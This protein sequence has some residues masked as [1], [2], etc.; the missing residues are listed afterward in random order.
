MYLVIASVLFGG[1]MAE[2]TRHNDLGV[3]YMEQNNF[4]AAAR[5]FEEVLKLHPNYVIG[6]IN[7]GIAYVQMSR[8]DDAVRELKEALSLDPDNPYAHYNLG[9]IYKIRGQY[10][11]AKMEFETVLK[12]DPEDPYV[13]HNLGIVLSKLKDHEAAVKAYEQV[14][15]LDPNN[16]SAHYNLATE[17]RRLGRYEEAERHMKKFR[18][19]RA[20][21]L[22]PTAGV[23]YLEQGKY[24][25]ALPDPSLLKPPPDERY[26]VKF[27]DATEEAGVPS[28]PLPGRVPEEVPKDASEEWLREHVVEPLGGNACWGDYDGDGDLDMYIVRCGANVL[29]RNEEGRFVDVTPKAGVGDEGLGMDA[30]W[31]DYDND[32]DLDLY[33]ANFGPNLL[34]RNEGDG[35]FTNM[36]QEAGVGDPRWSVACAFADVDHDGDLD[37]FVVNYG[38]RNTLYRNNFN[39]TFTDVTQEA[40]IGG[41]RRSRGVVFTDY[42]NDRD[43]D[44]FVLNDGEPDQLFSNNR[45]GT[46][47]DMA[48]EAGIAS[49][50]RS[51]SAAIS[52]YDRDRFMDLVVGST[53][54][55]PVLYRYLRDGRYIPVSL[56]W[57]EGFSAEVVSSL[58]YD[59]DGD[60]DILAVSR[61]GRPLLLRNRMGK[62]FEVDEEAFPKVSVPGVKKALVGDY[63]LD[64]DQDVALVSY[65]G[66]VRLF[67]NEGGNEN[68]WLVVRLV[69]R[70]CN[71]QGIGTKLEV[72]TGSLWQKKEARGDSWSPGGV[73]SFGLGRNSKVDLLRALWP[74]GV[75]QTEMEVPARRDTNLVEIDRKGTSCP[76]LYVNDGREIHYVTDFNGA[77]DSGY[78][79]RP[80]VYALPDPDEYVPIPR[81]L[82]RPIGGIYDLRVASQLEEVILL[83]QVKLL[84]VDHPPGWEVYPNE[85]FVSVPPYPEFRLY[86]VRNPVHPRNA[87]DYRGRDV[88]DLVM[89]RDR[90]YPDVPLE[91]FQGY[92]KVHTLTLDFGDLSGAGRMLLVA[93]GWLEYMS[94]TANLAAWQAGISPMPPRLEVPDGRGGWKVVTEDMGAP[95]GEPKPMV[96]D[97]TGKLPPHDCRLRITTNYQ[98]YWDQILVDTTSSEPPHRV[99]ELPLEEAVLRW[100]GYPYDYSPDGRKPKVYD[101]RR[102]LLTPRYNWRDITGYYTRYGDVKELLKDVDD[103]F[104]IM[105]H[106]DEV[107][108]K[109]G[110][111]PVPEGWERSFV[112]YANGFGKSTD[113]W[114]AYT[115]TVDPLPFHGMS[116]YPY[117]EG[118][119]YPD[120]PEHRDYLERYNTRLIVWKGE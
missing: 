8:Y 18:R 94:S 109:F 42:D 100:L 104:V 33:V 119:S 49:P 10:P 54:E 108:L 116:T 105:R 92:A 14:L 99:R 38:D 68:S 80:G 65:G 45:D 60:M 7:L 96:F 84:A 48:E 82:L 115:W 97:L 21:G 112:F 41:A 58:D 117:P 102:A 114:S 55:P 12:K 40:G 29:L 19:L 53:G 77:G 110:V 83:D 31:G 64:G 51:F 81:K 101:Y 32:G 74:D 107:A 61:D 22:K 71:R 76:I 62:N 93:Y 6:H 13:W 24:A 27:V 16:I 20:L 46:F 30:V 78:L 73:L 11:E 39:G 70:G 17:L 34:Y 37:I 2:V 86:F 88:T 103:R 5:E 44:F 4:A 75:R 50:G 120:D 47:T 9:L 25:E 57:P 43:V 89:H 52:D 15:R 106:G 85:R 1:D 79:I 98:I 95:A 26:P 23:R 3:V 118:E 59:N 63:D 111:L 36:T 113:L 72:K 35:T 91:R 66:G 56:P 90:L 69:G 28:F 87:V 67:R